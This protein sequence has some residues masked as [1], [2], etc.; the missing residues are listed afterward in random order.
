MK[1]Y[2]NLGA[3]QMKIGE[4]ESALQSVNTVLDLDPDNVK[5]IYRKGKV[6][7]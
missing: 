4:L 5:A 7:S 6:T 2:N 1:V 3:V